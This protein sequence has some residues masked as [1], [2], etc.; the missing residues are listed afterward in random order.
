MFYYSTGVSSD[1]LSDPCFLLINLSTDPIA[2]EP[3]TKIKNELKIKSYFYPAFHEVKNPKTKF[4]GVIFYIHG[5]TDYTSRYA[6]VAQVYSK[7]GYD[8]F[9]MDFPGH[10]KS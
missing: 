4:K 10:G 2:N 3:S 9:T 1:S 7:L 6:F 5:F 8:F